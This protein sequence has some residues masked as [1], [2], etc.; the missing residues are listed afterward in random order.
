MV[1]LRVMSY[2]YISNIAYRSATMM[3]ITDAARDQIKEVM[4]EH[5]GKCLRIIFD[6]YG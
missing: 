6:G 2:C 1:F 5:K 4:K 3:Q